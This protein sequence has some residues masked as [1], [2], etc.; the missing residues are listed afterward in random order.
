MPKIT[1]FPSGGLI[2]EFS[3]EET[4]RSIALCRA[5]EERMRE[6]LYPTTDERHPSLHSIACIVSW[7]EYY[8][9]RDRQFTLS[10]PLWEPFQ[11]LSEWFRVEIIRQLHLPYDTTWEDILKLAGFLEESEFSS[12]EAFWEAHSFGQMTQLVHE[13][14]AQKLEELRRLHYEIVERTQ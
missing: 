12:E 1:N 5:A 11:L 2:V 3:A 13:E 7:A 9:P 8:A 14:A 4:E 10:H 6:K